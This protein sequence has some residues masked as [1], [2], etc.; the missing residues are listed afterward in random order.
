M[1]LTELF[2]NIANAIRTKKGT[3]DKILATNFATEIENLPSG[4]TE[5]VLI[6]DASS[7][8]YKRNELIEK[9]NEYF[10][11]SQCSI[12]N[13]M[14]YSCKLIQSIPLLDTSNGTSFSFMFRYCESLKTIPS[15]NTSNGTGFD[16]MFAECKSLETIPLI[17]T[18]N[19]TNLYRYV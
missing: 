7:L 9:L 16:Y 19:G 13:N 10:D 6:N 12:F 17:N 11:F 4:G 14:F 3:S 8:C 18:S 2:T 5:K 1:T 15:M